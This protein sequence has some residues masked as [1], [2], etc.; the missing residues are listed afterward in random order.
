LYD[1]ENDIGETKNLIAQHPEVV[2]QIRK[3]LDDER[4]LA[5]GV[6]GVSYPRPTKKD[7]V[8]KAK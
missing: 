2:K 6:N 3:I 7:K 5:K 8:R 1:V 4:K